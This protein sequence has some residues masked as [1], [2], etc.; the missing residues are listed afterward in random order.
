MV[1]QEKVSTFEEDHELEGLSFFKA[2]TVIIKSSFE[3]RRFA[4]LRPIRA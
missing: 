4:Q 3:E 2:E 1:V